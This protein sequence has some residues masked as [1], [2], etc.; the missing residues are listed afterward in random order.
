MTIEIRGEIWYWKGPAPFHF[1]TVPQKESDGLK[2]IAASVT[3]GW[4][5]VP[6]SARVGATEWTTALFPKDGR[7]IVP[8]KDRVRVAEGLTEGDTVDL[9]LQVREGDGKRGPWE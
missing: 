4:G 9:W 3:Y 6:V 2:S 8:L 5:M 1:V 7:Y